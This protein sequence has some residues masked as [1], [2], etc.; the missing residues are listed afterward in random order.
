MPV[1]FQFC[2]T[3]LQRFAARGCAESLLTTKMQCHLNTIVW[4]A[5]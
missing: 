2:D 3:R 5:R 1:M 4:F